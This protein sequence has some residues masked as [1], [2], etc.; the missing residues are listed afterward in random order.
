MIR[1]K[2]IFLVMLLGVTGIVN[3]EQVSQPAD[4]FGVGNAFIRSGGDFDTEGGITVEGAVTAATLVATSSISF[5]DKA[6][7]VSDLNVGSNKVVIGGTNGAGAAVTMSGDAT[8]TTGG[9]VAISSGV[10]V[11][12]DVATNAAIAVSKLATSGWMQTDTNTVVDVTLYVPVKEGDILFGS[13]SNI[14]YISV[15]LTTNDWILISN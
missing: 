14:V 4:R 15:G 13:V 6:L 5:P 10:I 12:A 9:V 11:N 8:I 7:S 3:A 2:I 1:K